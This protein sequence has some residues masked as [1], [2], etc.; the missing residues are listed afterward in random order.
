[1]ATLEMRFPSSSHSHRFIGF[2]VCCLSISDFSGVILFF[3]F[4]ML[5]VAHSRKA[6]YYQ[7]TSPAPSTNS[8]S[9]YFCCCCC[10]QLLMTL[11]TY[12]HG[13]LITE[14][15]FFKPCSPLLL[16]SDCFVRVYFQCSFH[17]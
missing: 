13:Q 3:L 6:L 15:I 9:L 10:A 11:V 7:A 17:L 4:V 16:G 14:Q 1:V 8:L 5:G 2:T 12:L